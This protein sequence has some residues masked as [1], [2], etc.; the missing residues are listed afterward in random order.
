MEGG[1]VFH[2]EEGK[3]FD[4]VRL[5]KTI[6]NDRTVKRGIK[7]IKFFALFSNA[8]IFFIKDLTL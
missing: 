7:K 2:M 3:L 8:A 4:R 6:E 1:K 5:S